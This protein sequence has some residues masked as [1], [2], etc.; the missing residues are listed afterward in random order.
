MGH[1]F[2]RV[3]ALLGVAVFVALAGTGAAIRLAWCRK[4]RRR[5]P[6]WEHRLL[7]AAFAGGVVLALCF[8]DARWIEPNWLSV[9]HQ[10]VRTSALPAGVRLRL[11]Q[12]SDLHVDGPT[13]VLE[14]LPERVAALHPDVIL[15]TGDAANSDRGERRFR[16]VFS[17]LRARLGRYAVR[18]NHDVQWPPGTLFDGIATALNGRG[19]TLLGGKVVLC[20]TPWQQPKAHQ[21]PAQDEIAACLRAHPNGF[22][23]VLYHTPDLVEALAPL[24]PDLYLAGHTHGGQV[25]L[26]FYG[27]VVTFSKF[28]KKYEMGRYKVGHTVLYVNRGIGMAEGLPPV[29]FLCRPEV[30]VIDVVGTGPAPKTKPDDRAL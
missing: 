2:A 12:L 13:H 27:A 26:P 20:G 10:T 19:V 23:V 24:R 16:K 25:R 17:K 21:H 11:V 14:E 4:A 5:L 18:G 30:T 28:G 1:G 3:E 8:V 22:R 29:R 6:R 7:R 9:T 15:F